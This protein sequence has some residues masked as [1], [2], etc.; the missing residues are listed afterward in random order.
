VITQRD[1]SVFLEPLQNWL[2]SNRLTRRA[3]AVALRRHARQLLVEFDRQD[4]IRS[5]KRILRGLVHRAHSTPFGRDHDFRRIRT[6][7]DFRRLVAL[8]R[9]G[10]SSIYASNQD[11]ISNSRPALTALAIVDALHNLDSWAREGAVVRVEPSGL[12]RKLNSSLPILLQ[13]LIHFRSKEDMAVNGVRAL[14]SLW[15]ED[16]AVALEDPRHCRLRLLTDHSVYFEF[17][18]T[19]QVGQSKPARVSLGEVEPGTIY[20]IAITTG[21]GVWAR[22]TDITVAFERLDP[23]LLVRVPVPAISPPTALPPPHL[24]IDDTPGVRP[25]MLVHSPWSTPVD[26]G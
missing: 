18:P 13:M 11:S 12:D 17:I 24:Q 26:L 6:A 2:I 22:L 19:E 8:C 3:A 7:A 5:Q 20:T 14:E 4:P 23:P 16:G 25:E 15:T 1:Q 9:P 10:E 21:T